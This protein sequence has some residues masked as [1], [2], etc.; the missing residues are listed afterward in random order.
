MAQ[1]TEILERQERTLER[2]EKRNGRGTEVSENETDNQQNIA[3]HTTGDVHYW[4][5]DER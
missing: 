1:I 3:P 4:P 2:I 5:E